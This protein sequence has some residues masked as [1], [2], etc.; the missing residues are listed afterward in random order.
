[1][2]AGP[3]TPRVPMVQQALEASRK[4]SRALREREFMARRGAAKKAAPA[5]GS[6]LV[7]MSSGD[8]A[9]I[10]RMSGV[11]EG[12]AASSSEDPFADAAI[13]AGGS[14]TVSK[15]GQAKAVQSAPRIAGLPPT[16]P[17]G[18]PICYGHHLEAKLRTVSRKG[19]NKGRKFYCCPLPR[20]E[21]CKFF[22]WEDEHA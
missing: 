15:G 6:T 16:G 4:R 1:M 9:A 18:C 21:Q 20:E 10:R 7:P 13:A 22:L 11:K 2:G 17:N 8:L 12:A 14:V 19:R 3:A 5:S